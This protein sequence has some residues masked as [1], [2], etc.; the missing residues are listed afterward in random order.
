MLEYTFLFTGAEA[1]KGKGKGKWVL[2]WEY[3]QILE[4][5]YYHY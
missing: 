2:L 4:V 3:I 1:G 5:A